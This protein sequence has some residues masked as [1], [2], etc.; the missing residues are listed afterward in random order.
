MLK[1][2]CIHK[3]IDK[4]ISLEIFKGYNYIMMTGKWEF[5]IRISGLILSDNGEKDDSFTRLDKKAMS[6]RY[7][8]HLNYI[9]VFNVGLLWLLLFSLWYILNNPATSVTH[10]ISYIC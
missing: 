9:S 8:V 4:I 5:S 3:T 1:I 2:L 6:F 10:F 7:W